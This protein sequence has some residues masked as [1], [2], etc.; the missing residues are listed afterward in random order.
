MVQKL[1]FDVGMHT[2]RDTEFYLKKGF[3]VVAVEANPSLAA[4]GKSKFSEY[5]AEGRL[6]IHDVAIADREGEIEFFINDKHDDWGTTSVEFAERNKKLGTHN[7]PLA[8]RCTTFET[9]LQQYEVP[10]YVKV[11]IEG[12]DILCLQALK[13]VKQKPKFVSIEAAL[14]SFEETFSQLAILVELGY[15][16]FKIVNQVVNHKVGCPNPPLEGRYVD[17]QFDGTC[18]GPFGEESPGEWMALEQTFDRCRRLIWEQRRFGAGGTHYRSV[19][20]KLYRVW[21][22]IRCERIGW[23]D[24][25]AKRTTEC[26]SQS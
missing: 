3:N 18:S 16:Q 12:A 17:Y 1:I 8:V 4:A 5:I 26:I 11:D 14:G 21:E 9:V 22:A 25:H 23:Y 13:A 6:V 15:D 19:Y 7:T 24:F 20:H 2:G 10:Y